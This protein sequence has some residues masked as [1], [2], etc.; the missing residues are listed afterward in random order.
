MKE[1]LTFD[2]LN[3]TPEKKPYVIMVVGVN[4]AGKTTSISKIA[5]K[6]IDN[7]KSVVMAAAD[8][9]RA[10]AI[11]QL[12]FWGEKVGATVIAHEQGSDAAAVAF[13]ALSHAKA[14]GKDVVIV[15]TAGRLHN[16]SNLMK[17]LSKIQKVILKEVGQIDEVIMVLDGTTGQNGIQ[18]AKIFKEFVDLTGIIITKLDGTAKGGIAFSIDHELKLP[19][20]L[21]CVGEKVDD[22]QEFNPEFYCNA[23]LDL[24]E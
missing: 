4:G 8:T 3:L 10:A 2:P 20:K 7:D 19:I 12:Q 18:Q 9:F 1:N 21:V 14:K 22:L 23:L 15:D 24:E 13:D 17:E 11:E 6:Y 5:K 16:K